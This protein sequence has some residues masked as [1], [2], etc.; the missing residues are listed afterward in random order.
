MQTVDTFRKS[1]S[2]ADLATVDCLREIIDGSHDDL[3]ES[4][5]WNAPNFSFNG[6]D[7]ITLGLERKGGVRVVF[8]LGAKTADN[9]GFQF[10][11]MTGLARWP[12]PDRG[13]A[14]FR[15]LESVEARRNEIADLCKRWLQ[16]TSRVG[17]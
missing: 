11:D 16:V 6:Q 12:A 15:D 13:V 5:K 14:V 3:E 9:S 8:H 7:R 2:A 10:D 17:T 1:L 4:I